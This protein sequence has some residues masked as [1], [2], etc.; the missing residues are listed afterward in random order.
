[1]TSLVPLTVNG[2]LLV[3]ETHN[4]K[5]HQIIFKRIG[6]YAIDVE[7]HHVHIPIQLGELTQVADKAME[8]INIYATNIHKEMLIHYRLDNRYLEES[9]A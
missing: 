4:Q 5:E 2:R 3:T 6:E 7:F 1:M 8:I 9:P